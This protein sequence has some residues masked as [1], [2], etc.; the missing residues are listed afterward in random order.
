[1]H[2]RPCLRHE[3]HLTSV[4]GGWGYTAFEVALSQAHPIEG[5]TV[6]VAVAGTG[7]GLL[8]SSSVACLRVTVREEGML[9]LWRGF[10]LNWIRMAPWSLTFFLSFEQL[11]RVCGLSSF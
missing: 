11:R 9:A 8:Y 3:R 2:T 10:F 7:R 4:G 6:G 5:L 1:M